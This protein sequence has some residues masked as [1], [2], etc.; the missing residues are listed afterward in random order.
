[1]RKVFVPISLI[2]FLFFSAGLGFSQRSRTAAVK[3][4]QTAAK[5]KLTNVV[6]V[7]DGEGVFIRWSTEGE[8]DVIGFYVY[9]N[10]KSGAEL[11]DPGIIPGGYLRTRLTENY[12]G[13]YDFFDPHGD[14]Q[15]SYIIET[16]ELNG[17]SARSYQTR[18][19]TS[20]P[21]RAFVNPS[22]GNR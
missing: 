14:L 13:E 18:C 21:S 11:A 12:F 6:A 1:M 3:A 4:P 8:R 2:M 7:S 22:F 17:V 5:L 10:G 15:A 9:R 16:V 19:R 20:L